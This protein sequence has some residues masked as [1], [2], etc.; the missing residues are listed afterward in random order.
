VR[1]FDLF[2]QVAARIA[3]ARSDVLFVVAGTE[4]IFYGWDAIHIGGPNFKEWVL[5]RVEHDPSRFLFLGHIPPEQLA[6]VLCLSDLHLYLTVP[7][8]LSWSLINAMACARV[9]LASDVPPV[10]EVIE[11][12]QSGLVEPLFDVDR[13]TETAVRILD[14]PA[15]YAPLGTAARRRVEETYSL[16]VAIP[17]LKDY[18]ERM[19]SAGSRDAA[20]QVCPLVGEE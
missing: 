1:G 3:R 15:T 19:A 14:D 6:E 5:A 13:L 2:I 10:R 7:F 8:V 17:D 11:P 12:G 16:E 4:H 9:I 18:F 20:P